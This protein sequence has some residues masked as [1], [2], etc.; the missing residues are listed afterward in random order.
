MLGV[1]AAAA[2]PFDL[3]LIAPAGLETDRNQWT[4]LDARPTEQYIQGHLPGAFSFSW[5]NHT[6]TDE[7]GIAYRLKPIE[8]IAAS[9]EK[10][11]IHK[12]SPVVVYGDADTSWGGE[13]W[14]CWVLAFMGH[15]GPV[16]LLD[17]GLQA[18]QAQSYPVEKGLQKIDAK[19]AQYDFNVRK[20]LNVDAETLRKSPD[21]Y[22]LVDTRSLM[23]WFKGHL[24]NAVHIRWKS[25]FTGRHQKPIRR[26][27]IKALLSEHDI[28]RQKPVV[29]YCTGGIRSGYAWLVHQLAGLPTACNFEGGTAAWRKLSEK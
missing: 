27:A 3:G 15:C 6:R 4:I 25:F 26:Q 14:A 11:G 7:K 17:G 23:E 12:K 8:A 16:R 19:P 18:W 24:P 13:G 29:Y 1:S 28:D 5:E 10:M 20:A 21:A 9:F 2:K 22:Q